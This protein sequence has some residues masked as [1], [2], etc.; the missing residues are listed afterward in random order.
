[1]NKQKAPEPFNKYVNDLHC[2][3]QKE[4]VTNLAL[5]LN[6]SWELRKFLSLLIINYNIKQD[7]ES[8]E[9]GPQVVTNTA[10]E[11]DNN[12]AGEEITYV[13]EKA[14]EEERRFYGDHFPETLEIFENAWHY[15]KKMAQQIADKLGP[16]WKIKPIEGKESV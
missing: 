6:K 11:C 10:E 13:I 14:T 2:Y 15:T 3:D 4:A 5:E 1:M 16:E 12:E 8:G 9:A 7:Q